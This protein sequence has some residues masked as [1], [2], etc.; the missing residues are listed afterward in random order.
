MSFLLDKLQ[1]RPSSE[2]Y[3]VLLALLRWRVSGLKSFVRTRGLVKQCDDGFILFM[4]SQ[5]DVHQGPKI[6]QVDIAN[7]S[8]CTDLTKQILVSC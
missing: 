5:A 8:S 1:E 3:V 2:L 7:I 6:N 4:T